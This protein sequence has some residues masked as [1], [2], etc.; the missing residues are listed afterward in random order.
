M[1][2]TEVGSSNSSTSPSPFDEGPTVATLEIAL[3][4]SW[5]EGADRSVPVRL[6]DLPVQADLP[7]VGDGATEWKVADGTSE[8]MVNQAMWA[9]ENIPFQQEYGNPR[10]RVVIF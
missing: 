2:T 7:L 6:G 8:L 10:G 9:A 4:V 5:P 1:A 3:G